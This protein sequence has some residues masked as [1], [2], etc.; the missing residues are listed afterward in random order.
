MEKKVGC[1]FRL[2]L[3]LFAIPRYQPA[4]C[5]HLSNQQFI[6]LHFIF[7]VVSPIFSLPLWFSFIVLLIESGCFEPFG[8]RNTLTLPT[9]A[10]PISFPCSL[11]IW[12]DI[13]CERPLDE[14]TLMMPPSV[15]I[16]Y[17]TYCMI[18]SSKYMLEINNKRSSKVFSFRIS[19]ACIGSVQPTIQLPLSHSLESIVDENVHISDCPSTAQYARWSKRQNQWQAVWKKQRMR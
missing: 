11:P 17:I 15:T 9:K 1:L 14:E 18:G 3:F 7:I 13:P 4:L 16:I 5:L 19:W 12:L 6:F 8:C 10:F 2:C